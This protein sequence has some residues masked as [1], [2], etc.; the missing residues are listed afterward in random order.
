MTVEERTAMVQRKMEQIK[1][2]QLLRENRS[3]EKKVMAIHMP[4]YC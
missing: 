3:K 2:Q 1:R 4:I